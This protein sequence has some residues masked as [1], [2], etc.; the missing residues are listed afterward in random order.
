MFLIIGGAY[1]GKLKYAFERFHFT[2]NDVYR[3]S[4]GD[5]KTPRGKVVYGLEDW[6]L[7]L[8]KA[9]M[10]VAEKVREFIGQ[11]TDAVVICRDI[12]CGVVPTDAVLR[13]WREDV[14]RSLTALSKNASEVIRLFC[15]IP[16]GI[17]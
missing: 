9:D 1:Q 12:S 2:E 17:K 14:G 5:R 8:V 7:A 6:I 16:T 11:N 10:D 3:C 13:K 15:G 4:E